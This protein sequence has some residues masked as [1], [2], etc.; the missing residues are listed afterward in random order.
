[1]FIYAWKTLS[2]LRILYS[3][4]FTKLFQFDDVYI[5][6]AWLEYSSCGTRSIV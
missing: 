2:Y 6:E 1:M 5:V 3:S 4:M